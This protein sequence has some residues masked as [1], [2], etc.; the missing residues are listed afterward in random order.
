MAIQKTQVIGG[1]LEIILTNG[2]H[3]TK[4]KHLVPSD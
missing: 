3:L 4:I 2:N 1:W